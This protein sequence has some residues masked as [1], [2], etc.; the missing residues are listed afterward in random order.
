MRSR[1]VFFLFLLMAMGAAAFWSLTR[2]T[3]ERAFASALRRFS[4]LPGVNVQVSLFWER[5]SPSGQGYALDT[6]LTYG[7]LI[8]IRDLEHI[9][10]KGAIG[11]SKTYNSGDFQTAQVALTTDALSVQLTKVDPAL[12]KW[13]ESASGTSTKDTWFFF[14]RDA[15]LKEKGFSSFIPLGRSDD[16]RS[17]WNGAQFSEWATPRSFQEKVS[18]GARFMDAELI[19]N[20][21]AIESALI[22]LQSAWM[23]KD[24]SPAMLEWASRATRGAKS[25]EWSV[26]YADD[27]IGVRSIRG[28]WPLLDEEDRAIGRVTIQVDVHGVAT[29]QDAVPEGAIN[30]TD[31]IR[32]PV[33]SGFAPSRGRLQDTP[34][35][36]TTDPSVVTTT[37]LEASFMPQP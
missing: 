30:L 3:P 2:D 36:S 1:F 33:S 27:V 22:S 4:Q 18:N 34:T 23:A 24:P 32:P 37:D 21:D 17:A 15:L 8:D 10:A 14:Q 35:A 28:E 20:A 12:I 31:A 19:L 25:G 11:Y 26:T 29:V 7:G 13:F 9:K 5:L 16:I 6:W